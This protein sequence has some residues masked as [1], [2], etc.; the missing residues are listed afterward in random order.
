M[1]EACIP[2][3]LAAGLRG[4][5][6][7][8]APEVRKA[9][10]PGTTPRVWPFLFAHLPAPPGGFAAVVVGLHDYHDDTPGGSLRE[11]ALD[12]AFLGPIL[13]PGD[14]AEVADFTAAGSR[15]DAWLV[16]CSRI[17]A[18]RR[19]L[20]DLL[21]SPWSRY[22]AARRHYWWLESNQPYVGIDRSLAG[23]H[24]EDGRIVG[25]RPEDHGME[26]ALRSV[27]WPETTVDDSAYRRKWL[28]RLADLAAA[29]GTQLLF[30]RM[31]TQVLPRAVPRPVSSAVLDE[32]AARPHVRVLDRDLFA[33]LE[34]PEFFYD[35]VHLNRAGA[36]RFTQLL[37]AALRRELGPRP[38]R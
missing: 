4:D 33:E 19:D 10:I 2:E 28:G 15:R 37:G 6:G 26:A 34:R 18:W 38:G 27:V 25:L 23:V 22:K 21:L 7:Q 9:S 16:G 31:P 32:L 29:A 11:N 36:E 1:G 30:V 20:Q 8:P 13:G 35:H 24:V 12:L 17:Y 5:A 3:L 14:A